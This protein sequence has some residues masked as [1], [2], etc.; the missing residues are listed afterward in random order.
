MQDISRRKFLQ[1]AGSLTVTFSISGLP[2]LAQE[3]GAK[4]LP[5]SLKAFP[6]ISS[7]IR[8]NADNS[9]TL[10]IGKV[11]LGQ[12]ILTAAAQICADELDV[13]IERVEVISGDTF[14][15]PDEGVTAGSASMPNCAPAVQQASAEARHI[16]LDLAAKKLG[17]APQNLSVNNGVITTNTGLRASYG[18]L[19]L[20]EAFN[21]EATGLVKPKAIA[22]HKIIGKSMP[23]IDLPAKIVGEA[24]F[25]QELRHDGMVHG[26]VVRAAQRGAIVSVDTAPIEAMPGVLKVVRNGSFL[27]IIAAREEQAIA[28]AEALRSAVEW[29]KPSPFVASNLVYDWLEKQPAQ[30]STVKEIVRNNS[31][32]P[33]SVV[34]R[35]YL[36]PYQMHASIG[37]S[38]AIAEMKPDGVLVI[39]TH[40]Q[41]VFWTMEAIARMLKMDKAKVHGR[42]FHGAGC[43]GHNLADDAAADAAML[44]VAFPGRPVRLQYSRADENCFEPLGPAMVVKARAGLDADG[45]ILDWQVDVFSTPHNTRP[46]REAGFLLAAAELDPPIKMPVPKNVPAPNYGAERN[47]IVLYDF[48]A[49]RV[50]NHFITAM[51]L[52]VSALRGL[53]AYGNVFAT[54]SFLDEIA[55]EAK[56]DPVEYRLRYMKDERAR[57][58]IS[59]AAEAFGWANFQKSAGRGRGIAF[60]Q[61][62]NLACYTAVA[63]EVSIDP[64]TGEIRVVRAVA[65]NDSG[66]IVNPDGVENQIEGGII[67]SLSWSLKEEVRFDAHRILSDSWA[68]YPIL[69]FSE[70]PPIEVVQIDRPGAP[71]LGTGEGSQGPTVA[72]LANAIFDAVGVRLRQ[73]P[74]TPERLKAALNA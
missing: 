63:L 64:T 11:E 28:A 5:G 7:W 32:P 16:L 15:T 50:F 26:R 38:A 3:G 55:H 9:V 72:A 2:A 4:R 60:A 29:R 57:A 70:V 35:T 43:Y 68:E 65:A 19:V 47:A 61:Y 58:V 74:F 22:D 71:Y 20:G 21:R 59:K 40:S 18:E 48:P 49:H 36:R 34:E 62:K 24:A 23:R 53:G 42:H 30:D 37:P 39:D 33:S 12:G 14:V 31:A 67:Q 46:N 69:R 10:L 44:A 66:H 13:D 27:G 52:R 54:E 51:P 56:A 41:S 6:K 73:L 17:V 8:I 45:G 25:L 1:T